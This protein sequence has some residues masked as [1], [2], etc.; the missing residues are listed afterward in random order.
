MNRSNNT[1]KK[2]EKSLFQL[3]DKLAIAVNDLMRTAKSEEDLR[4]TF[5]KHLEPILKNIGVKTDPTYEHFGKKISAFRGRPDAVHGNVII[6]YENPNSFSSEKI[7]EHAYRQLIGYIKGAAKTEKTNRFNLLYRI[8]G[9]G[10]DGDSIFFVK[11]RGREYKTL[12]EV[13]DKDFA[14]DGIYIFNTESAQTLL[15]HLRSLSRLPL[16]P[17]SLTEKFGPKSKIAPK[18][19]ICFCQCLGILD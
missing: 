7:V 1:D 14:I 5:E 15:K 9:V 16:S 2:N 3:A 19:R 12:D 13:K 8:V 17:E 6:E 18:I 4:I 11:Y 10:F